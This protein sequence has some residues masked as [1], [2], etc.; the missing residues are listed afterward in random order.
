MHKTKREGERERE[1]EREGF[2][3]PLH[4]KT[5]EGT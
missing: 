4:N 5:I 2:K 1:R 3:I